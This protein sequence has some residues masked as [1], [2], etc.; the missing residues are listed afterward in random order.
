M[1]GVIL[2]EFADFADASLPARTAGGDVLGASATWD[3]ATRYEPAALAGL[4]ACASDASG[5]PSPEILRRFGIH[6]FG[7]FAALYPAFFLDGTPCLDFLSGLDTAIHAE[8]QKLYPDAEF[9]RFECERVASD[10]LVLTYTSERGLADFA[11]GLLL[12]CIA[13]FDEP[14]AL[15]RRDLSAAPGRAARF[16][17]TRRGRSSSAA[18]GARPT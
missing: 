5:V 4:V 11:E 7:R 13:W 14:I 8:V 6:L 9:P 12:G 10:R 2:R 17:L 16:S 1:K 15:E 3:A 18:T